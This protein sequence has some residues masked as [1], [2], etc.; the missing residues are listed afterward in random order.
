MHHYIF[1]LFLQTVYAIGN[2]LAG[3]NVQ[4]RMCK[5]QSLI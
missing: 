5:D 3:L 4:Y 2:L 1:A